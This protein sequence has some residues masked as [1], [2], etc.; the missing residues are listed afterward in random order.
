MLPFYEKG[1]F[2][3][4]AY[5][6]ALS[7]DQGLSA[8]FNGNASETVSARCYRNNHKQPY[9]TYEKVINFIYLPLQGPDHCRRR[10]L[11]EL[12]GINRPPPKSPA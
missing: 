3:E 12:A 8:V 1:G 11:K 5:Q 10:Y 9:K 4:W 2:K 7:I 6:I